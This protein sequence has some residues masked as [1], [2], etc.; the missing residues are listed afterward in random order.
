[1][2]RFQTDR[3]PIARLAND[4]M[5]KGLGNPREVNESLELGISQCWISV[6]DLVNL[7]TCW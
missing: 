6:L 2:G 4:S 1:V 3:S 7:Y 5:V